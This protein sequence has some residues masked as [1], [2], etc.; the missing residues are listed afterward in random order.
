M[1]QIEQRINERFDNPETRIDSLETRILAM[2]VLST[3]T[4]LVI[5]VYTNFSFLLV[6]TKIL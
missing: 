4:L 5:I 3:F 2:Y 1:G 6:G